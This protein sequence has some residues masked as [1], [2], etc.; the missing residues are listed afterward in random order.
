MRR[1][2]TN[3]EAYQF[4]EQYTRIAASPQANR[5]NDM[6]PDF[7]PQFKNLLSTKITK[8]ANIEYGN[9]ISNSQKANPKFFPKE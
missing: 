2:L 5:S 7:A 4:I 3:T 9:L 8:Y 6:P 1:K